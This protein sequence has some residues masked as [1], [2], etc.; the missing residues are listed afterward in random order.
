MCFVCV[1]LYVGFKIV[2][3]TKVV[4]SQ[5]ADLVWERPIIDAYEASVAESHIGF[6]EEVRIMM[7]F[8][9]LE[10]ME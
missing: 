10:N 7:G 2:K 9:K 4:K 5:E 8:K 1:V 6:W 3:K